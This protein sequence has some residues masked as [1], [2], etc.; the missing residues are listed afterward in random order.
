MLCLRAERIDVECVVRGALAGAGVREYRA[1][2]TL[3]GAPLP[4]GMGDG[5]PLDP[6]LFTP[7]TKAE[8]G[9]DEPIPHGTLG[10]IVGAD[11][12]RALEE[13]SLA[14]FVEARTQAARRPRAGGHQF[15]SGSSV[16][17]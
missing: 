13:R 14:L 5:A 7:S 15:G 1:H 11:V 10:A 16:G 17:R 8:A 12:A 9:H 6:P 3:N 2:G 4:P